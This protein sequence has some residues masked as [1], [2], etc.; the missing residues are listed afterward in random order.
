MKITQ[1]S[2]LKLRQLFLG[3]IAIALPLSTIASTA[4][5]L[6]V[7]GTTELT[8]F[9]DVNG[10]GKADY[11]QLKNQGSNRGQIFCRLTVGSNVANVNDSTEFV[12][13]QIDLGYSTLPRAFVDVNGDKRADYCRVMG[14]GVPS[15]MYLA[16]SLAGTNGFGSDGSLF[17]SIQGIDLGYANYYRGFSDV[18]GDGKADFCRVVGFGDAFHMRLGCNLAGITGFNLNQESQS[19]PGIF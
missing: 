8:T 12:S 13:P 15:Q 10:D 4:Q 1:K 6:G 19:F 17:R 2:S 16:C 18:N 5:A 14:P 11:C 9:A 7:D 3:A